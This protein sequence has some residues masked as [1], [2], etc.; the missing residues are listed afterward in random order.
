MGFVRFVPH[1]VIEVEDGTLA[2]ITP[3]EASGDYP[4]IRH[5]GTREEF[6]AIQE[7][8]GTH[9]GLDLIIL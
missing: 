9:V 3:H 8:Q 2:D 4:F 5:I 7:Q 1:C 6:L